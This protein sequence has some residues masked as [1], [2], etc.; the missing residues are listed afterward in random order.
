V[1]GPVAFCLLREVRQHHVSYRGALAKLVKDLLL[2]ES[3]SILVPAPRIRRIALLN[4]L[5]VWVYF[6]YPWKLIRI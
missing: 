3:S 4:Q 1:G 5:Q 6:A 2:S